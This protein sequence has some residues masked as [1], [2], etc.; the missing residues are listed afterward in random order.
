MWTYLAIFLSISLIV[1]VF[2][3]RVILYNKKLPQSSVQQK[4]SKKSTLKSSLTPSISVSK[5]D[6]IR[7][8]ALFR[9]GLEDRK[10][11]V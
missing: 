11:V 6:K 10:S 9:K 5:K 1:F 4:D 7:A 2:L 3:R 8:E